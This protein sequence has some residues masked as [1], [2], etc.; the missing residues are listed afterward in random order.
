[1]ACEGLVDATDLSKLRDEIEKID[2]DRKD[3]TFWRDPE[4]AARILARQTRS[5]ETLTRI[6]RLKDSVDELAGGFELR[7][8]RSNLERLAARLLRLES[9]M[10][11]AIRELVAMGPDGYWDALMEITPIGR[12]DARDFLFGL[13]GDWAR[14]RRL[15]IVLLREPM[16]SN[17]AIAVLVKGSFAHGYLKGEAGHHRLRRE[18]D[19]SVARVRVAPLSDRVAAVEFGEQQPLKAVGQLAGKI[20]SRVAVLATSLVLQNSRTLA[21]NRELALDVGPSW[22]REQIPTMPTVRRY[23]LSPFLV[24]DYLTKTD[25]TRGDILGPKLFHHLLCA[26][27]DQS[28]GT[29][30]GDT[31]SISQE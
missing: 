20:R 29:D 19:S 11:G 1:M 31:E 10:T 8:T 15:E 2:A 13:Y 25:F 18:R 12:K 4:E 17:E 14:E 7:A 6:E 24:R 27:I 16:A 26:R 21:E 30:E 5:L 28:F 23:D 3:Y 9:A 22:P